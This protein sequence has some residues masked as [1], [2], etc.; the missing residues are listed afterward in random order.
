MALLVALERPCWWVWARV[1]VAS[2]C[3]ILVLNCTSQ[4]FLPYPMNWGH[5]ELV[6][7]D[8]ADCLGCMWTVTSDI[9]KSANL[10]PLV[11]L[12]SD[13]SPPAIIGSTSA[14]C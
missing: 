8:A 12:L 5:L 3:L 9:I 11:V 7:K 2:E 10:L 13:L 14:G 1:V 4:S 6:R